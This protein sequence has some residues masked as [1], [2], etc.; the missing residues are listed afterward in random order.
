MEKVAVYTCITGGYDRLIQ[1]AG[2]VSWCDFICFVPKGVRHPDSDG[3]WKIVEFECGAGGAAA[4][5]RY[6]KMHPD[7]LL[8]DHAYSLWLDGN[9]GI[10]SADFYGVLSSLVGRDVLFA[11]VPH[12]SRDCAYEEAAA[13]VR[14]GKSTLRPMLKAVRFLSAS[15]LPR[16]A[17]LNENN[18][19]FRKHADP[20]VIALDRRWWDL[21][22]LFGRDQPVLP[23]CLREAG[24]AS[25]Q[26]LPDGENARDSRLMTYVYHDRQEDGRFFPRKWRGLKR[27]VSSRIMDLILAATER[28]GEP[29]GS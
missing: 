3:V 2:I 24:I 7:E 27:Y 16:H 23:L 11:G 25:V 10:A 6:P 26:L 8:P 17:G 22:L 28:K 19:V 12:P 18:M 21:Y 14:G 5:S 15:G 1:P 20:S 4:V 9:V 29:N 13:C